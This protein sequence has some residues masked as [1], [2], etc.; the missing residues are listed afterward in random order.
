MSPD[1]VFNNLIFFCN[2]AT[3]W[4]W[5]QDKRNLSDQNSFFSAVDSKKRLT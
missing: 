2:I 5:C 1:T 3:Y 4:F